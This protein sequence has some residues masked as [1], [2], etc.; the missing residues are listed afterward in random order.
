MQDNYPSQKCYGYGARVSIT[1]YW[2]SSVPCCSTDTHISRRSYCWVCINVVV[3]LLAP[4]ADSLGCINLQIAW[5]VHPSASLTGSRVH[6]GLQWG[7]QLAHPHRLT[8]SRPTHL[9]V[10]AADSAMVDFSFTMK[11]INS[12]VDN[13]WP[14]VSGEIHPIYFYITY[15]FL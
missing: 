7:G 3:S 11:I 4:T 12:A 15:C 9:S 14:N 6:A 8:L 1:L 13:Y 5:S 10:P 2:C